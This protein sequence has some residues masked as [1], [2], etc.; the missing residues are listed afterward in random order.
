[1]F[2]AQF[3][4]GGGGRDKNALAAAYEPKKITGTFR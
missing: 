2:I 3:W 4:G 1:M